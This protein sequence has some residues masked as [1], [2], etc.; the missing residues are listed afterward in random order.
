MSA[1]VAT[2]ARQE[3]MTVLP[4]EL[5]PSVERLVTE[6]GKP[7]DNIYAEK[8]Q[9]L[10]TAPLY[11]SWAGPG[12]N[13]PFVAMSNVGMFFAVD[14]PPLVPDCLLSLDVRF[15]D[16]RQKNIVPTFSGYLARPPMSFWKWSATRKEKNWARNFAST[17]GSAFPIM[18]SGIR[19]SSSPGRVCASTACTSNHTNPCPNP[20]FPK[21]AWV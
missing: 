21:S 12:D 11:A 17:P 3:P 4:P 15:G 6:D 13:R 5:I 9:R 2:D 19:N 18:G 7:V 10:L 14:Q 16:L 20:G 8:Q 1:P